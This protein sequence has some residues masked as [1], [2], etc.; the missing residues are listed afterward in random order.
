MIA[1]PL[2]IGAR[3]KKAGELA[4][5]H[6]TIAS[7]H[8]STVNAE[9]RAAELRSCGWLVRTYQRTVK[10]GGFDALVVVV[11]GRRQPR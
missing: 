6:H 2:H 11:I 4:R 7:V 10:A 8:G 1:E 5:T 9:A 3:T